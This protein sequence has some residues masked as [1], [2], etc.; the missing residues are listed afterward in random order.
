MPTRYKIEIFERDFTFRAFAPIAPPDIVFDYLAIEKVSIEGV[1]ITAQKGD[2]AHITDGGGNVVYQG[3]IDDVEETKSGNT[4]T[5]KPLISL[6]DCDVHFDRTQLTYL[7]SFLTGIIQANFI[8]SG[9][10]MQDVPGMVVSSTSQTSGTLNLK[11]NIHSLYELMTKCLTA[12]GIVV[13]A[14]ISPEDKAFTVTIGKQTRTA[15]VESDLRGIFDKSVILGDSYGQINK[16]TIYNKANESENVTYYLQTDGGISTENTDRIYPVFF[17]NDYVDVDPE[18][19]N[20]NFHDEAYSQAYDVLVPQQYDNLIELSAPNDSGILNAA[21][22]I[23][24]VATIYSE[25]KAYKSMLTGYEKTG[26]YTRLIFGV[27]RADLTKRLILERR[28]AQ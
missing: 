22:P 9:D 18:D 2:Y 27:V 20:A 7:E 1:K 28:G 16:L 6:F 23:G 10:P 26:D 25:G 14:E 11:D 8:D 4:L 3:F 17:S 13:T 21:L 15:V 19:E 12:Y 5:L 24:T